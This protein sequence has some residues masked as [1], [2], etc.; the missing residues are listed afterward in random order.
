MARLDALD[1]TARLVA[2]GYTSDP[3][4]NLDATLEVPRWPAGPRAAPAPQ[5]APRPAGVPA[6]WDDDEQASQS[7]LDAMGIQ[8]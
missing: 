3:L 2:A 8:L 1:R 5:P 7:F 6:W 4:A